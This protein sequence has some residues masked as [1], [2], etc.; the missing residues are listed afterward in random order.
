[1][2][3]YAEDELLPLSALQHLLFC[4]RQCALIHIEQAWD[5]N[6]L[7]AEGRILHD[8]VHEGEN[9]SRRNVRIVRGLR[10]R[11]LRLGLVGVADVVEFHRPTADLK[12]QISDLRWPG[13]PFPIEYKRGKPKPDVCD[14]VQLCAQALCLE[15]MT[16]V[17]VPQG[18]LFYG[19]PRRRQDVLFDEP[20]RCRTETAAQRLHA[21]FGAGLTPPAVYAKRCDNCSLKTLCLPETAGRGKSA[22]RY[23]AQVV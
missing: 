8:R 20:L 18:A 6:R 3:M 15:E 19:L 17:P 14:S 10:L 23:L 22:R 5:E 2:D 12:S 7:T 9:E 16:G 21:L 11:S 13:Q 4:E 1:M